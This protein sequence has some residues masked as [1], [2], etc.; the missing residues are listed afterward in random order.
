MFEQIHPAMAE[1]MRELEAID[2][3]DRT[4]GTPQA[5]RLRQVPPES[6]RFIALLAASAPPG[7]WIE[8]GTSAGYSTLWLALAARECGT[9]ITTYEIAE[10]KLALARET[11][12]VAGVEDLVRLVQAD[13][14]ERIAGHGPIGFCFIDA[15]KEI[16]D[17][18][19]DLAM[20]QLVPGG[21]IVADNAISHQSEL[22]PFIDR[23]LSDNR[24][25]ALV[26]PIGTGEL[27]CRRM[28]YRV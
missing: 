8:V 18:C 11:F 2:A 14:R 25:D 19:Y 7:A 1:R 6:G 5:Q 3:H 15:E 16:Y 9:T 20:Q 12:R 27:L 13:A 24:V 17:A 23:V 4:D 21:L 28:G 10:N 26:V 22:Q